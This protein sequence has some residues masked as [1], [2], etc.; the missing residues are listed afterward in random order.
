[1]IIFIVSLL[2]VIFV[3][4]FSGLVDYLVYLGLTL[5]DLLV[6]GAFWWLGGNQAY[7]LLS[8]V[9]PLFLLFLGRKRA[10]VAISTN[11][12]FKIMLFLSIYIP[13]RYGLA[14]VP[15]GLELLSIWSEAARNGCGTMTPACEKFV[16]ACCSCPISWS[17]LSALPA[18]FFLSSRWAVKI[19]KMK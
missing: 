15:N 11:L 16:A 17:N 13:I 8:A 3:S 10:V 9:L 2:A 12:G 5:I 4:G 19:V 18:I 7:L 6:V 1:M 14:T